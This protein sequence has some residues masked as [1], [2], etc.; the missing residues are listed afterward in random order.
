M[1]FPVLK[2]A[3]WIG[4]WAAVVMLSA[5]GRREA[6]VERGI[7]EGVLLRGN[8]SEPESLDPHLVRGAVEWTIVGSLF[9][10][11]VATDPETLAP[12]PAAAES[13][14]VAADGKTYTFRLRD[15]LT[16]SDGFP[17]TAEDFVYGARRLLAP[18]L[19]ASHAENNLFFVAGAREYQAG[20]TS[21]FSG[22]GV[23]APD[24]QTVVF[25]LERPTPF[26]PSS[27][28]LFFPVPRHVVE[29][30]APMDERRSGWT[31]AGNLVGN[32]PFV[33]REWRANQ[34]LVLARNPRYRDAGQ[35]RLREVRFR[36]IENPSVEEN[37]F[38]SGQLHLTSSV[39]LQKIEAYARDPSQVLKTVDDRGV[40]F[41][42]LNVARAPL[43]DVR[44]RRA[45]ALT[46]DREALVARVIKGGKRAANHF[47][48]PG[49]SDYV[50][51]PTLRF[52]PAEGRRWL[53]AAGYPEGKGFP[54]LELLV[55]AR[56][57]HRLVAEAVQAMW[58][59][60]LG[61]AVTLRSEETQV[62]NASKRGM[63]FQMVRG[64]WNATTYQD[65]FYFLGAW[66]TG[67]LYNESRWSD[68]RFDAWIERTWTADEAARRVAFAEAERILLEEVPAIPLFFSTQ[69]I[70]VH[71]AVRGWRP[72]PFADRRLKDLWLE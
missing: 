61:V 47:T 31:R 56:D 10:G 66:T 7:R 59:A 25:E 69:V 50:P 70:L 65:P 48:P 34:E 37:A 57:H 54:P 15:G 52:D 44:V 18:R 16:W 27:L 53:A 46:V 12:V 63:D 20:R 9:E 22:V 64:S 38:R 4:L 6:P 41:Y 35:V 2:P 5:C 21:D 13:W 23:R 68:A 11:L 29:R 43:D 32:G 42:S 30:F 40:Y 51:P 3:V 19:G 39:P 62:L 14:T 49:I 67:A 72:R 24:P 58:R 45:L 60:H 33:L 55:D 26:F 71:P 28:C 17:L 36:P 1:R 8:S